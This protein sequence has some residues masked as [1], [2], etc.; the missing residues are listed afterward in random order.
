VTYAIAK[1]PIV[2]TGPVST[3]T[4]DE[5][6]RRQLACYPNFSTDDDLFGSWLSSFTGIHINPLKLSATKIDVGQVLKAAAI[7]AGVVIAGPVL[8]AAVTKVTPAV[9]GVLQAGGTAAK[10]ALTAL[11]AKPA[12]PEPSAIPDQAFYVAP[13]PVPAP[14]P[15]PVPVPVPVRQLAPVPTYPVSQAGLGGFGNIDPALL[16]VGVVGLLLVMKSSGGRH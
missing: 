9:V 7:T 1:R 16:A 3:I 5:Y 8:A 4:Y 15:L 6:R 13:A 14:V 2:L 12:T 10:A 11:G